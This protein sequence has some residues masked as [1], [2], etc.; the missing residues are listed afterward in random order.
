MGQQENK[1]KWMMNRNSV[2][3]WSYPP[4]CSGPPEDDY[5]AFEMHCYSCGGFL[6]Q[7]PDMLAPQTFVHVDY[8]VSPVTGSNIEYCILVDDEWAGAMYEVGWI[9]ADIC[10]VRKCPKC[11]VLNEFID[12]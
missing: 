3:G 11:G 6:R 7:A 10:E 12:Y 1:D 4:G 9:D 8:S 2:F 5:T